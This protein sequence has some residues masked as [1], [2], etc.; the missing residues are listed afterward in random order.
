MASV[1]FRAP[2]CFRLR[3]PGHSESLVEGAAPSV[4]AEL[5]DLLESLEG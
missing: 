2:G 3:A 1:V 5:A 4:A